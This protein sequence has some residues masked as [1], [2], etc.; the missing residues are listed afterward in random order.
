MNN[1]AEQ[2]KDAFNGITG[3]VQGLGNVFAEN[4]YLDVILREW[5][6]NKGIVTSVDVRH[7]SRFL[8]GD[9]RQ[10]IEFKMKQYSIA[11]GESPDKL[12]YAPV[13]DLKKWKN[14][15]NGVSDRPVIQ[16][17]NNK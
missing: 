5:L 4:E 11:Q 15:R 10:F 17:N 7:Y 1:P 12:W 13:A 3:L 14:A 16:V 9:N 2:I 8:D 6:A